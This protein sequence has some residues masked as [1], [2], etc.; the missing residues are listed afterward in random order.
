MIE[1]LL[2]VELD[3]PVLVVALEGW[4]DAGLGAG[5]AMAALLEQ[6]PTE[7]I[8]R[9][10][11]DLLIDYRARRPVMHVEDGINTGLVWQDLV[12]RA[13]QDRA[14]KDVLL[15]AGPEPD[16][17][18][19]AFTRAVV[20]LAGELDVRLVVGLG[21]FPAP[22][23]H[24]RP[25]RVVSTAT[26]S[27]LA[28]EVGFMPGSIDVPSGILGALERGFA[29][30]GLPAVGLW[31]RVP[32]YLANMPYPAAGAALVEALLRVAGLTVYAGDL[33]EAAQVTESRIAEMIANSDEHQA[34]VSQLEAQL[35]AAE[36]TVMGSDAGLGDLPTGDELA[37][38]LQ[39]YLR[40]QDNDQP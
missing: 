18:W 23:P 36:P 9:F 27:E 16:M 2:E 25:L 13:G 35:D 33:L 7:P 26:T 20:R 31:A 34:M 37:A 39:R 29:D 11:S 38:E 32:H 8:V 40:T 19:R 1:R 3:R 21:A 24:T 4:I 12:L 10:D 28:A 15:L 14:G 30:A 22:V 5:Q 17:Q 6:I